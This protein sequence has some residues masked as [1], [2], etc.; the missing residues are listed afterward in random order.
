MTTHMLQVD[1]M[2]APRQPSAEYADAPVPEA[3]AKHLQL[4]AAMLGRAGECRYLPLDCLWIASGLPL[5]C[6]LIAS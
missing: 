4:A 1:E 5:D 3:A 6:L 2:S